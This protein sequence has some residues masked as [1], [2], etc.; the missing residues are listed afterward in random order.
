MGLYWRSLRKSRLV[1]FDLEVDELP[2]VAR[3][4]ASVR[5]YHVCR[6]D[7]STI[8]FDRHHSCRQPLAAM[9]GVVTQNDE[10]IDLNVS[11]G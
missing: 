5:R 2:P 7:V 9:G 8:G 4:G 3:E 1:F 6:P 11:F 10:V